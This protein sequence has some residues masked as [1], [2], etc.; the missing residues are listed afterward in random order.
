MPEKPYRPPSHSAPLATGL[1]PSP[2]GAPR[3]GDPWAGPAE[4]ERWRLSSAKTMTRLSDGRS[5]GD[6]VGHVAGEGRCQGVEAT[7][8]FSKASRG[9]R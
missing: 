8:R 9:M 6:L 4:G 5:L 2:P 7:R 1:Q 3:P